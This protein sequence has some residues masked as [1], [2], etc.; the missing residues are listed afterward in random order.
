M[1][2]SNR[3]EVYRL[4][5][6]DFLLSTSCTKQDFGSNGPPKFKDQLLIY[7][8]GFYLLFCRGKLWPCWTGQSYRLGPQINKQRGQCL[9]GIS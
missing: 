7:I 8:F 5:R 4:A 1:I 6:F 2:S 3:N 9:E